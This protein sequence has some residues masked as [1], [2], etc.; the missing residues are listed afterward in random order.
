MQNVLAIITDLGGVLISVDKAPMFES[1]AKRSKLSKQEIAQHFSH[2]LLTS[3][4]LDFGRGIITPMEFYEGMCR[5]LALSGMSFEEFSNAY[6]D[7]FSRKEE[8]IRLLRK[9]SRK[10]VTALLSNTDALHYEA[11]SRLLGKDMKLFKEAI[12]S[13]QVHAAKPAKEIFLEAANKLKLRPEQCVYIDDI[14]EY[15]DAAAKVGMHGIHFVS[16]E[17]L[18]ERLG[19]LGMTA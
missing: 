10:Y 4:D 15:S 13:F 12:L 5:R 18:K 14:K 9:L 6:C 17:Q 8:V 11:W 2:T 3:A 16:L 19:K 7:V 1:L